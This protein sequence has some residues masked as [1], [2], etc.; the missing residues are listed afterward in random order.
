MITICNVILSIP[1]SECPGFM[2]RWS[3]WIDFAG[4]F[5]RK[6]YNKSLFLPRLMIGIGI[7]PPDLGGFCEFP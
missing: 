3:N 4:L 6:L 7:I 1:F 2:T 5:I